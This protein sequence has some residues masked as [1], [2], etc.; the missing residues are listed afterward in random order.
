M[1]GE[2]FETLPR[3]FRVGEFD[4]LHLVELMLADQPPHILPIRTRLGPEAGGGGA[5]ADREVL[6]GEGL[7]TM[8]VGDRD[9]GGRYQVQVE[10]VDMKEIIGELRELS[11]AEK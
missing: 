9:L 2:R 6:L 10:V 3:A 8:E 1:S 4:E 5:V 7:V 11:G